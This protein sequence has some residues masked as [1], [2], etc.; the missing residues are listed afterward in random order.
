MAYDQEADR[1]GRLPIVFV[2]LE[3]DSCTRDYGTAP[4]TAAV[5]VTG[6]RKCYKTY[7]SCQDREHYAA[8]PMVYRFSEEN[9]AVPVGVSAIPLLKSVTFAP[10]QIAPGKGL[11]LRA[12][13][14]LKFRDAP[15]PDADIDPYVAGRDYDT[16]NQGTF[17]GKFRARNPFYE[18]RKVRIRS[19]YLASPFSWGNFRDRLYVI[20]SIKGPSRSGEVEI[21]AKDILKLAD[22]KRAVCPKP[23]RGK[24]SAA[25]TAASTACALVPAGVGDEDYP[26]SG[27]A[28]ISGEMVDF[29]RSGDSIA[30][31]ARGVGGTTAKTHD[32]NDTFQLAK[33]FVNAEIQDVIY[34]L[35]TAYS[36]VSASYITKADWDSERDEFLPGVWSSDIAE[37]TGVT[38]LISELTEQGTCYIWWD[39]VNQKIRFRALRPP[40]AELPVLTDGMHFL[41]GSVSAS[42]DPNQR[43]SQLI[44]YFDRLDPTEKLDAEKNYRQKFI[45]VDLKSEGEQEHGSPRI[46]KIYSR[47]FTNGSLG[48][49]EALGQALIER[50]VH[51]PRLLEFKLDAADE[52]GLADLFYAQSR[53][54][55]DETGLT[56]QINMQVIEAQEERAGSV[57]KYK[58]QE[59]IYSEPESSAVVFSANVRD[60]NLYDAYVA[61]YGVPAGPVDAVFTIAPGVIVGSSSPLTPAIQTGSAWPEGSIITLVNKG[62]IQGAGGR[63]ADQNA[64]YSIAEPGGTAF[65]AQYPVILNNADGKMAGG[66]GGGGASNYN[67]VIQIHGASGGGGAGDVSGTGGSSYFAGPESGNNGSL[68]VGGS[69]GFAETAPA[70]F[71]GNGG[72]P[73][74]AGE[75]GHGGSGDLN[76]PG[77]VAGKAVEGNANITWVAT[78]LRLGPMT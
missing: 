36:P 6:V 15:W 73:G 56:R 24:L 48:R 38:T 25:I 26:L 42:D 52:I 44:I 40:A 21:V 33:R 11:G 58:A 9:A 59:N 50:Y 63:G 10:Q 3:F 51:P 37:P 14:T 4:C 2:E 57:F 30:L 53:M 64:M 78:G 72:P 16:T 55:Q 77:G 28:N 76:S 70:S 54:I 35:L 12:S 69:G 61:E 47:W 46:K 41:S 19:G 66:G 45:Q 22:D 13:V 65:Y 43:V 29:T 62:R 27:R 34:E 18:G 67:G 49:V 17:W 74:E 39:E 1:V 8:S 7:G 5:G 32:A 68:D 71:G 20:E 23:S 75:D 31:T 60:V